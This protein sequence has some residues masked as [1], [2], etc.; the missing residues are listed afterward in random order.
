[1]AGRI[2]L[3]TVGLL[4][5]LMGAL[6]C[7]ILW[8][9]FERAGVTRDWTP[10]EAEV[11]SGWVEETELSDARDRRYRLQLRYAYEHEGKKLV[12]TRIKPN[13][14]PSRHRVVKE[15]LLEGY[16]V[17]KKIPAWMNPGD[18]TSAVLEH[19]TLA[20]GYT[21]WFPALFVLG[22]MGI[23]TRALIRRSGKEA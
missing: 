6:F 11:V 12:G 13:D 3:F 23:A 21:I 9:G 22:G 17:G 18:P 16:P 14:R 10:V 15:R 7:T 4:L 2:V 1:M 5:V 19:D 20:P 8:Q